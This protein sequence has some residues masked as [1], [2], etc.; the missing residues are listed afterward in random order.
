MRIHHHPKAFIGKRLRP[1]I[2][3][4]RDQAA[5]NHGFAHLHSSLQKCTGQIPDL[6]PQLELDAEVRLE[7]IGPTLADDLSRL[8][9]HG[10]GNPVPLFVAGE[11]ALAGEVRVLKGKHLALR[12]SQGESQLEA[13]GWNL[14][15]RLAE[16]SLARALAAAFEIERHDFFPERPLRLVLRDLSARAF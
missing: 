15:H 10:S 2:V 1:P 16:L 12:L 9:P 8:A 4:H 7:E 6:E 11:L 14:A 5:F 3:T 13:I